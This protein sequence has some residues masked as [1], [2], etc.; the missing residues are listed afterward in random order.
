MKPQ[1]L[2]V[3]AKLVALGDKEWTQLSLAKDLFMSQSEISS[4]LARCRYANLLG[5][6]GKTVHRK[7]FYDFIQ[8]GLAVVFPQQPG[9][10]VRGTATAHSAAPLS[11][12]WILFSIRYWP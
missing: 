1:D 3:L 5:Y 6:K 2:V 8:Y 4:A 12:N 9:V 10:L 11:E 7:P